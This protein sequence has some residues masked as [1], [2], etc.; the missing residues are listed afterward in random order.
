MFNKLILLITLNY[1]INSC[2]Y[3]FNFIIKVF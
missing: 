2:D 3:I 1:Q